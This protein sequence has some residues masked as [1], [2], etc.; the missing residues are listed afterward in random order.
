VRVAGITQAETVSTVVW[1]CWSWGLPY[2][3][4]RPRKMRNAIAM[5]TVGPPDITTTF[6]HQAIL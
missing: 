1:T 4:N 6:F 5:L 2:V 3:E